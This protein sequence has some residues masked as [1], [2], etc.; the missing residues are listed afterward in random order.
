MALQSGGPHPVSRRHDEQ[1]LASFLHRGAPQQRVFRCHL[2]PWLPSDPSRPTHPADFRL[3]GLH[4]HMCQFLTTDLFPHVHTSYWLCLREPWLPLAQKPDLYRSKVLV[5]LLTASKGSLLLPEAVH[6]PRPVVP[7]IFKASK[8]TASPHPA[9]NLCEFPQC[10]QQENTLSTDGAG[11]HDLLCLQR[12]ITR[13]PARHTRSRA[14]VGGLGATF[15]IRLP[16]PAPAALGQ[17]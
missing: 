11:P 1:G 12:S 14:S 13:V 5:P 9:S 7:S 3:T 17:H 2:H 8:D 10:H 16:Q 6:I 15:R 4:N